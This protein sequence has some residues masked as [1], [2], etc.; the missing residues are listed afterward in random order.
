MSQPIFCA[1]ND[2]GVGVNNEGWRWRWAIAGRG[3]GDQGIRQPCTSPIL[4]VFVHRQA[5]GCL[6]KRSLDRRA[7]LGS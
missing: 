5:L 3:R 1:G 4:G 7:L 6:L 2:L